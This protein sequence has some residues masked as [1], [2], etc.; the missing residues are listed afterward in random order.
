MGLLLSVLITCVGVLE[1]IAC[2]THFRVGVAYNECKSNIRDIAKNYAVELRKH[3][4][5]FEPGPD[6]RGDE[7]SSQEETLSELMRKRTVKVQERSQH[8]TNEHISSNGHLSNTNN[9]LSPGS[10]TPNYKNLPVVPRNSISGIDSP[11]IQ[12]IV[13]PE[14]DITEAIVEKMQSHENDEK[15]WSRKS[16]SPMPP[17]KTGLEVVGKD[18]WKSRS[19][20]PFPDSEPVELIYTPGLKQETNI[21]SATV[22]ESSL[23]HSLQKSSSGSELVTKD[24]W[25]N[26]IVNSD[27]N[28][29][30]SRTDLEIQDILPSE[31]SSNYTSTDFEVQDIMTVQNL[32]HINQPSPYP[33]IIFGML[34]EN[35]ET[36]FDEQFLRSLDGVKSPKCD[37]RRRSFRKKRN[38]SST[39]SKASREDVRSITSLEELEIDKRVDEIIN[40]PLP[41]EDCELSDKTDCQYIQIE[42]VAQEKCESLLHTKE[43]A[44]VTKQEQTHFT[45]TESTSS[46]ELNKP[47]NVSFTEKIKDLEI[48]VQLMV[49]VKG[50]SQGDQMQYTTTVTPD[51]KSS[52]TATVDNQG[53]TV[54]KSAEECSEFGKVKTSVTYGNA[55]VPTLEST[56]TKEIS[57]IAPIVKSTDLKDLQISSQSLIH[58]ERTLQDNVKSSEEE[59]L[60]LY[61]SFTELPP[62]ERDKFLKIIEQS[63]KQQTKIEP[64]NLENPP[65]EIQRSANSLITKVPPDPTKDEIVSINEITEIT[66]TIESVTTIPPDIKSNIISDV[67]P[68][69]NNNSNDVISINV[70]QSNNN[71]ITEFDHET[72]KAQT[73]HSLS[74]ISFETDTSTCKQI[75]DNRPETVCD[76]NISEINDTHIK[77][78]ND[79]RSLI[80][81]TTN[82]NIKTVTNRPETREQKPATDATYT[83]Q[84]N[85]QAVEPKNVENQTKEIQSSQINE[86]NEIVRNEENYTLS[87]VEE[88]A[89]KSINP[90]QIVPQNVV[91]EPSLNDNVNINSVQINPNQVIPENEIN[92]CFN[93]EMAPQS[94]EEINKNGSSSSLPPATLRRASKTSFEDASRVQ[95]EEM[96]KRRVSSS[97]IS[98]KQASQAFWVKNVCWNYTGLNLL[99]A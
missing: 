19:P 44:K 48:S 73:N 77:S 27:N 25:N 94:E 21:S 90:N 66:E 86:K 36:K 74:Q 1:V 45:A 9:S 35:V 29:G 70:S 55:I 15:F 92:K 75:T 6:E 99:F 30:Y 46:A 52:S 71:L 76:K 65:D 78:T 57:P 69:K 40:T 3:E 17:E 16:P 32:E 51:N 80:T 93:G 89:N 95:N 31:P 22:L 7:S 4:L 97:E 64:Q 68:I 91:V 33:E 34:G 42:T 59:F 2:Y 43:E 14:V 56:K 38:S 49:T 28:V 67:Q 87:S 83:P 84:Q 12:K 37:D 63:S 54:T 24:F 50:T 88:Q 62:R 85:K 81:S 79:E 39:S 20:S 26:P 58:S 98:P 53:E 18:F 5:H 10:I 96:L 13:S 41:E 47:T 23:L 72:S 82:E 61:E 60:K 11:T 8:Y